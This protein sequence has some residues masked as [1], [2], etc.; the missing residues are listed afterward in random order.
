MA[1]DRW[2]P[3]S[4]D[5]GAWGRSPGPR[6]RCRRSSLG[7]LVPLSRRQVDDGARWRAVLLQPLVQPL[8]KQREQLLYLV[9]R[10]LTLAHRAPLPDAVGKG[11]QDDGHSQR[12]DHGATSFVEVWDW[13]A[14]RVRAVASRSQSIRAQI[15]P[16]PVG[17]YSQEIGFKSQDVIAASV[18]SE[19]S[20]SQKTQMLDP[21]AHQAWIT[22]R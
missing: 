7:D 11:E 17:A 6:S 20:D 15:D 18:S 22:A 1:E 14:R 5:L 9:A 4:T 12:L 2:R 16:L 10:Q 21:D 13:E 8:A 19:L 3:R